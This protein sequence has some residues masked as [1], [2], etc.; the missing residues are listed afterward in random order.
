MSLI[1]VPYFVAVIATIIYTNKKMKTIGDKTEDFSDN[2]SVD[3]KPNAEVGEEENQPQP[4]SKKEI[5]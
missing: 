5:G 2:M 4:W 1:S 3:I